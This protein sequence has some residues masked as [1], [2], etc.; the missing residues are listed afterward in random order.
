[1]AVNTGEAVVAF[2]H[3]PQVGEAVA[4][5]VVNTASRLQSIA[6]TGSVVVG[7]ATHRATRD[8]IAY[9]SLGEVEVEG[10]AEPLQVWRAVGPIG[11]P[12]LEPGSV[13]P[14]VP[15]VGRTEELALLDEL[16]AMSVHG[17]S[18][19]LVTIVGEPGIGKTRL[20]QAFR[21]GL[22]AA[23]EAGA[24]IWLAGR[25]LAYGEAVTYW[26]LAE[27]VKAEAGIREDDDRAEARRKLAAA[28][29]ALDL[30]QTDRDWL[31]VRLAPLVGVETSAPGEARAARE[32]LFEACARFVWAIAGR[33]PLVLAF[34]DLHWADP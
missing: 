10:K 1:M 32:E 23:S 24:P 14:A 5:D 20:V 4:G 3:G 28:L 11:P 26:P 30:D 9:Q 7:E 31:E 18:T 17:P 13:A 29:A 15:L 34:E 27:V 22:G 16:F 19:R 12:G 6:S 25:C 8:L 33:G 21:A 2:G